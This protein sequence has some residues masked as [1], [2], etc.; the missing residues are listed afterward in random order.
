VGYGQASGPVPPFTMSLLA[1]RSLTVSRPIVFHY[2]RTPE[3]LAGMAAQVF[4]AFE[5]GIIRPIDP[6]VL[7]I[8]QAAEAHRML[9]ARQSPGGIVLVPR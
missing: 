6:V 9:E 3:M 7:P 1:S 2:L 8:D 5:H 4:D